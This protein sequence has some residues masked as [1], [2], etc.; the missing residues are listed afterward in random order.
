MRRPARLIWLP[1]GGH[2]GDAVMVAALFEELAA[3]H[4]GLAIT[5]LVRRNAEAIADLVKA[6]PAVEVVAV[7]YAPLPALATL[8]P[9]VLGTRAIVVAPPPWGTRP[10]VLKALCLLARLRGDTVV[11]FDDGGTRL[12]YSRVVAHDPGERYL[13]NLRRAAQGAGLAAAERGALPHLRIA[14]ALPARFPYEAD[15]YIVVHPFPHLSTLK[16]L[17]LGRWQGLI[18]ALCARYPAYGIVVTGAEVDRASA[19]ALARSAGPRVHLAIGLP[20][21]ALAGVIGEAA[22]YLGVDTGPTHIAG[23]LGTPSVVLAQQNEPLWL[24]TYNPNATLLFDKAHCRCGI[25]GE[26]C[27]VFEAGKPYRRCVYYLADEDILAAVGAALRRGIVP[28]S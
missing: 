24:P 5:Y 4:P 21:G 2:I 26:R 6:N 15:R 25:P 14:R 28:A 3:R 12:P 9:R 22:L 16:T 11:A 27:E 7:P 20:L 13:D 17:P 1:T 19:E 8:A 18:G 23:V 10:F